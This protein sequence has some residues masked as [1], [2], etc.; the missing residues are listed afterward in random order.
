MKRSFSEYLHDADTQAAR[1]TLLS[2][3]LCFLLLT[4]LVTISAVVCCLSAIQLIKEDTIERQRSDYDAVFDNGLQFEIAIGFFPL[5]YLKDLQLYITFS[6]CSSFL[7]ECG[8]VGGLFYLV[9]CD[10]RIP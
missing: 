6:L 9:G 10:W 5:V 1:R 8:V 4:P 7:F 2:D 3:F